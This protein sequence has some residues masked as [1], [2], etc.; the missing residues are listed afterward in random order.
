MKS[1]PM[2]TMP[3]SLLKPNA[4]TKPITSQSTQRVTDAVVGKLNLSPKDD[5]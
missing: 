5:E 1:N 3:V 2:T 4:A